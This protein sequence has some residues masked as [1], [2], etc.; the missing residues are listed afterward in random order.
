MFV[1]HLIL[2][3]VIFKIVLIAIYLLS[4]D[5]KVKYEVQVSKHKIEK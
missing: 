1:N 5:R 4:S 3:V 2:A